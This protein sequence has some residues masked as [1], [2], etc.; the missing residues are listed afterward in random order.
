MTKVDRI[1]RALRRG[2]GTAFELAVEL[3]LPERIVAKHA[4]VLRKRGEVEHIGSITQV[5][6]HKRAFIYAIKSQNSRNYP[7]RNQTAQPAS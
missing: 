5:Y 6:G 1:R 4:C 3:R 7:A 2:P